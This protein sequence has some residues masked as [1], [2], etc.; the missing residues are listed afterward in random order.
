MAQ[1]KEIGA[2]GERCAAEYLEDSGYEIL[3]KN[4]RLNFAEID[5]IA[6]SPDDVCVFV[7]VKTRKNDKFGL[8]CQAVDRRKQE[9]IIR[10]A[11]TYSYDGDKR[12]DVIEVY[13]NDEHGF[14]P[15]KINHIENAF[16]NFI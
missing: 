10:A 13:Y 11:M 5:I 12:F 15:Q 8:A 4:Y 3:E 2:A 9:H 1:N 7:E 6:L 14:K 16:E